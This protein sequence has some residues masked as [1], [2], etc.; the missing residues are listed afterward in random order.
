MMKRLWWLIVGLGMILLWTSSPVQAADVTIPTNTPAGFHQ[1]SATGS[2]AKSRFR[3]QPNWWAHGY[4]VSFDEV[5]GGSVSD[6]Q[7]D[8]EVD[9]VASEARRPLR[10]LPDT[11]L[12]DAPV[13]NEYYH[14]FALNSETVPLRA[15]FDKYGDYFYS[16]VQ[17]HVI[18]QV[19]SDAPI[20]T[21]GPLGVDPAH[22]IAGAFDIVWLGEEYD[23][24][25]YKLTFAKVSVPTWFRY[26][27]AV[28]MESDNATFYS[29]IFPVLVL[30]DNWRA[31]PT[32]ESRVL[33]GGQSTR[34][35]IAG[36][37][38]TIQ[39]RY[40]WDQAPSDWQPE[41]NQLRVTNSDQAVNTATVAASL[42]VPRRPYYNL[43][44]STLRWQSELNYESAPLTIY[45]GQLPD[46]RVAFGATATFRVALPPGLTVTTSRWEVGTGS[47]GGGL[48]LVLPGVTDGATVRWQATLSNEAG[49]AL[50]ASIAA[51][52]LV[53]YPETLLLQQVPTLTF[54]AQTATGARPPTVAEMIAGRFAGATPPA[55]PPP[56]TASAWLVARAGGS[57]RVLD[58][59]AAATPWRVSAQLGRFSRAEQQL[60]A[61]VGLVLVVTDEEE[62]RPTPALTA[63]AG[64]QV[65]A[66]ATTRAWQA[67][68]QGLLR[69]EAV[70]NM[71]AGGYRATI[72]WM[73]E[74]VPTP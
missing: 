12:Y 9:A 20:T 60:T 4:I 25:D 22:G 74:A 57:L 27:I 34:V 65:V 52:L 1:P 2:E 3:T 49:E 33:F 36:M 44:P 56:N 59:R 62:G 11:A 43:L 47:P 14:A 15:S 58:G 7:P 41:G 66:T 13:G 55:I 64:P 8:G 72:T 10:S 50:P 16:K 46:Q 31:Q 39:P 67:E 24:I 51:R 42:T 45:Q 23:Y 17:I 54:L 63:G 19:G 5:E 18:M 37:E 53:V 70:N 29:T 68:V 69:V 6:P 28:Q 21:K 48:E 32:A 38:E 71:R 30:P 73:V 35:G 40:H 61:D 26:Q